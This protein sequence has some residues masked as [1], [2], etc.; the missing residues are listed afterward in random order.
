[1]SAL[2]E[3]YCSLSFEISE[4]IV[5]NIYDP[6]CSVTP[7][8]LGNF[9]ESMNSWSVVLGELCA[10]PDV[11]TNNAGQKCLFSHADKQRVQGEKVLVRLG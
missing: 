3:F 5:L 7:L 9:V 11:A 10:L 2:L 4:G 6:I 8:C 1:M